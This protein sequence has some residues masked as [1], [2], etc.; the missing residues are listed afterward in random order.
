MLRVAAAE[1]AAGAGVVAVVGVIVEAVV[2][3]EEAMRV[4]TPLKGVARAVLSR[5]P[6]LTS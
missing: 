4:K 3:A 6:A 5:G 2:V 1:V